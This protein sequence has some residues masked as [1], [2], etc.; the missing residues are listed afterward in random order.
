MNKIII[1]THVRFNDMVEFLIMK[2]IPGKFSSLDCQH[3][4]GT[5]QPS[6]SKMLDEST[7]YAAIRERF[8]IRK[9]FNDILDLK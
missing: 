3:S 9:D 4:S 1:R 7:S 5:V 8:S 2:I 6:E